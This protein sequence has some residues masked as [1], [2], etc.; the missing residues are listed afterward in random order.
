ME[1]SI[2]GLVTWARANDCSD[3][4]I[5]AEQPPT[6]RKVGDLVVGPFRGSQEDYRNLILSMLTDT[7][8]ADLEAGHDQDF[9]FDTGNNLRYRVNVYKQQNALAAAIRILRNDIPTL[10]DLHLPDAIRTLAEQPRGIVLVTGPTGSGKST[11]LAAMIDYINV[12]RKAHIITVEDP[13]EYVHE[14]KN[15]LVH[16][17]EVHRDVGSFADAL[18]SAMREDPDVILVGEMRDYETIS[19]AVTAAETGHL[20]FSTLHTTGASQTIDRIVDVYPAHSQSMIRSQLSGVMRGVITQTLVP[21]ADRSGRTVA[22]EILVGTD[23][24]LNLIR[25]GKFHQLGATMQ[26]SADVGMHTL[27]GDLV[28]LV[29][30]GRITR[31]TAMKA[32]NNKDELSQYLGM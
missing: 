24:V 6:F 14:H 13:I 17:R 31:E 11:T 1:L 22:T 32:V 10:E 25:E 2:N 16:Q 30:Q 15:C 23:A 28:S 9:S 26:S 18:R 21:L 8:K 20:V 27:A 4:H 3:L 5:T 12:H 29:R 19:A 7:Q